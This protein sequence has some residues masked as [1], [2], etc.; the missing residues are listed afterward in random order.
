M[1]LAQD[2]HR[3]PAAGLSTQLDQHA[4]AALDAC[5]HAVAIDRDAHCV[6]P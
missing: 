1:E 4:V 6:E 5:A 2:A 3:E